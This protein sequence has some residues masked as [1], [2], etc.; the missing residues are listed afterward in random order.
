MAIYMKVEGIDGAVTE[1]GHE[2]WIAL[3]ST[4]MGAA[5]AVASPTGVSAKRDVTDLSFSEIQIS[6]SYDAA[7]PK[8]FS[9]VAAKEGKKVEFHFTSGSD[10]TTEIILQD[11]LASSYSFSSG[12]EGKPS[13]SMSLNYTKIEIKHTPADQKNKAASPIPVGY[14]LATNQPL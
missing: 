9:W 5:R 12:G 3:D 8:L 1:K 6:K 7:S 10:V 2:K 13:E 14:D 11:V 4:S